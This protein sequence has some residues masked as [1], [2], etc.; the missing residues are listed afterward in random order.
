MK[1]KNYRPFFHITPEHGWMN[2]PNGFSYFNGLYHVFAQYYPYELRWGPMHWAHFVSSDLLKW[3]QIEIALKPDHSYDQDFGCFSGSALSFDGKHILAYTGVANNKQTQCLAT[4]ID[5]L[6]YAK[7][8]SNPIIDEQL[9]PDGYDISNFRDPKIFYRH[10]SFY[11]LVGAK[12]SDGISSL[13]LFRFNSPEN[14]EFV[15]SIFDMAGLGGGMLECCDI[16]FLNENDD[17][18]VLLCSPQFKKS[19]SP[20]HYQN[21]HSTIA[22]LG[23]LDF[24]NGC[25]IPSSP[26]IELDLG[27]D[28]YAAQTLAHD[29]HFY[30]IAWESMWDRNY[31]SEQ[32][33]FVGQLTCPREL[34]IID[35]S[36]YQQFVSSLDNYLSEICHINEISVDY[37]KDFLSKNDVIRYRFENETDG[38]YEIVLY[39]NSKRGYV[40]TID[41]KT[42]IIRFDRSCS[43]EKI[44]NI[45]GTQAEVREIYIKEGCQTLSFDILIDH[46]SC[47]ILINNGKYSFT[48]LFYPDGEYGI[49]FMN[50]S[51]KL[52]VKNLIISDLTNKEAC[53]ND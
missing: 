15:R 45:N 42:S 29:H 38:S 9:L 34:T 35:N 28:F 26:E 46:C 40:I 44:S 19:S 8:P 31:P 18:C 21:I 7:H 25:F 16:L 53:K 20:Y 17:Q 37:Q 3:K 32:C 39:S 43:K 27:F 33:G 23:Q 22:I 41:S 12:R 1:K 2:D 48:S 14:V 10:G 5:G 47:E 6:N 24:T 49:S 13:L 50:K 51:N 4:S 36:I 52:V 30:L 11:I